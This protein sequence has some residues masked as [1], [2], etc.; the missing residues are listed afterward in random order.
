[1]TAARVVGSNSGLSNVRRHTRHETMPNI[2]HALQVPQR[3]P[4]SSAWEAP[5]AVVCA[6]HA[7]GRLASVLCDAFEEDEDEGAAGT[8]TLA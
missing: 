8:G 1:M 2:I 3:L 5:M 4:S 6:N 7:A